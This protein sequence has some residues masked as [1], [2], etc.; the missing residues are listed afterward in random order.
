[1]LAIDFFSKAHNATKSQVLLL[2]YKT[3]ETLFEQMGN[4]HLQ[5]FTTKYFNFQNPLAYR[6]IVMY[7]LDTFLVQYVKCTH[8]KCT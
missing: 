5:G 8:D 1:M 2:L 6:I 4:I 3:P 7:Y